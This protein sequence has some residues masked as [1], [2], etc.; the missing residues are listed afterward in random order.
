MFNDIVFKA[1]ADGNRR[2]IISLLKQKDMT[3]GEIADNFDISKPS[4]SEHLKILKHADLIGSERNGQFIRYFLNTSI[5][6]EVISY[7]M[8]ISRN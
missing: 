3:A 6:E 8:D 5:I 4:I 2:K 1:L 7:F